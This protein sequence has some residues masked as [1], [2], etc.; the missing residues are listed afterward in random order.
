MSMASYEPD[1][2]SGD[3]TAY[4]A[5]RERLVG[6]CERCGMNAQLPDEDWCG[7]CTLEV[8]AALAEVELK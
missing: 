8:E 6:L 3:E 5:H 4:E 1:R 2:D 7:D